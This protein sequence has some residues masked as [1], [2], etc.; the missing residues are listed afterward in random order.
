MQMK[1][2]PIIIALI[3]I[4][5][6][7]P[8]N[9]SPSSSDSDGRI[10]KIS[11]FQS[12]SIHVNGV[13]VSLSELV[14]RLDKIRNARGTVWYYRESASAEP[15]K[16]AMLVIKEIIDRKLPIKMSTKPDFSDF[17]RFDGQSSSE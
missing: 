12:G 15:P 8:K 3:L 9:E 13:A 16:E 10:L 5:G 14:D 4:Y 6:C 7:S 2:L 11:V 1:H 17:V